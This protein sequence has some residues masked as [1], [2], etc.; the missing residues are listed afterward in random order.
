MKSVNLASLRAAC[1]V[2]DSGPGHQDR[3]RN[4]QVVARLESERAQAA[5]AGC[6][7]ADGAED[8]GGLAGGLY[9]GKSGFGGVELEC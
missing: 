6:I 3:T 4:V 5:D 7:G 8:L 9:F 2:L 1:V